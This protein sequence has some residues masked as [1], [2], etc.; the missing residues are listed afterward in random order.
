MSK[1]EKMNQFY[2]WLY[3]K[4]QNIHVIDDNEFENIIE[5]L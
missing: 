1:I 3:T 4:V 5:K 2:E